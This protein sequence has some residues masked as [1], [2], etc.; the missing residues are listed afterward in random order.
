MISFGA[1]SPLG[2]EVK[3]SAVTMEF[4]ILS[5]TP[6]TRFLDGSDRLV[7]RSSHSIQLTQP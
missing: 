3:K 6:W 1:L 4:S 5:A 2:E 7:S